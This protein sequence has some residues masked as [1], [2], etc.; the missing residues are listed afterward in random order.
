MTTQSYESK[1]GN[2]YD[3]QAAKNLGGDPP[4]ILAAF[5]AFFKEDFIAWRGGEA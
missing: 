5:F 1:A 3:C 2:C 4:G